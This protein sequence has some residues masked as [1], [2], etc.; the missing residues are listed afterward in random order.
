MRKFW[1]A[2]SGCCVLLTMNLY[3]A[4]IIQRLTLVND[5]YQAEHRILKDEIY[6]LSQKPTY[7]QGC[8]D[9][10][11]KMGSP[12]QPGAY[13]DGYDAATSLFANESYTTGYHNAI[14]QFGYQQVDSS[15]FLVPEPKKNDNKSSKEMAVK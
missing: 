1:F 7:E 11:I 5:I 9:T 14:Q 6:E 15:R 13:K 8:R 2:V 4:N 3:Q 12:N 10:L